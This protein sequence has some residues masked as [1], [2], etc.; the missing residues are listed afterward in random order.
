MDHDWGFAYNI[1]K[2]KTIYIYIICFPIYS[3]DKCEGVDED[4][5]HVLVGLELV[6][7]KGRKFAFQIHTGV[8]FCLGGF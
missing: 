2:C 4:S 7:T 1:S 6:Q 8:R 5:R 3:L